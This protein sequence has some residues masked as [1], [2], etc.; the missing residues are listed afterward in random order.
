MLL[1]TLNHNV[2][3]L[4][5]NLVHQLRKDPITNDMEFMIVDNGS[6]GEFA[7]HTTHKLE[8]N[9][10]F[11]GG[12]NVILEYF[13]S[14]DHDYL[15]MLNNDLIFHGYNFITNV[16][17]E[18]KYYDSAVY[19]PSVINA[20]I[21]QC[22]WKQMYNW[23]S[24]TV[25]EVRWIDFQCPILRRDICEIIQEFPPQ[26]QYGWGLD[27]Y[28]GVIAETH[29]LKTHVS[30]RLA[31]AHLNSQT[32]R[33]PGALAMGVEEFCKRAEHGLNDYFANSDYNELYYDLRN[34]GESYEY[35]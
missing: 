33:R 11:G 30:D 1:S 27:F 7:K 24:N 8:T 35:K 23:G 10:Y 4:T 31:V 21:S 3:D 32:F 16:V 14:T 28:A 17:D 9:T 6:T 29:G 19:S 13:L 22:N 5:D 15:A 20:E 2:P 26:L 34:W 18:M 12:F 25:R